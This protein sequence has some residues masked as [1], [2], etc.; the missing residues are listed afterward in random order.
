MKLKYFLRGLGSGIIFCAIILLVAYMTSGSYRLTDKEIISRAEKLGMVF[1]E[2]DTASDSDAA[3]DGAEQTEEA[4]T[5]EE[6]VTSGG[7]MTADGLS[8]TELT[9]ENTTE[10]SEASTT[11]PQGEYVTATITVVGGMDS[12]Q[13][14][15]LLEDAGIVESAA[16]FDSFLNQNGYSTRIEVG[17]FEVHGGMTYEE[18]A[19]V[20]SANKQ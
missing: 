18:L 20:L 6:K 11:A 3:K 8:T 14:A 10:E 4:V 2:N 5:T 9:T 1:E 17:T 16:D 7:I 15:R 13:V 19:D 12:E